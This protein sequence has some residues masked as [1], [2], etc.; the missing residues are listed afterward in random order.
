ML[1]QP[2]EEERDQLHCPVCHKTFLCKYGY[3][4]HLETHPELSQN[5]QQCNLSFKSGRELD[6]HKLVAHSKSK[7]NDDD[8]RSIKSAASEAVIGFHDLSFMDFS[9]TKFPLV[10]KSWCEENVRKA[11]SD[12]HKYIC[13]DCGKAFPCK[14]ALIMHIHTHNPEKT[15]Q[16]PLCE[17]DFIDNKELHIHM[18]KHMSDKA[19]DEVMDSDDIEEDN[20]DGDHIPEMIG[21]HD[22]LASCGLIAEKN[23]PDEKIKK[24]KSVSETI[25]NIEKKENND[26]FAKLGQVFSP[27]ISPINPMFK[28][29][30]EDAKSMAELQKL[31]QNSPNGMLPTF[32]P[33]P[34]MEHLHGI[35][36]A[37]FS[38]FLPSMIPYSLASQMTPT[39]AAM[40]NAS[41]MMNAALSNQNLSSP[42]PTPPPSSESGSGSSGEMTSKGMF[43]C[44]YCDML[45]PNYRALKGK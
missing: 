10:A 41:Q 14:S 23:P 20:E 28:K 44:K 22:F 24:E 13:K 30:G 31:L 35:N 8:E 18:T 26:Y 19:F 12:Y 16:C 38:A 45:F 29:N 36:L 3:Q 37:Q 7:Q 17:C 25:L 5:C 1:L 15:A 11:S 4:S 21:K 33:I 6:M 42:L 27:F 39:L 2:T 43:P 34:G 32:P 40:M 9:V